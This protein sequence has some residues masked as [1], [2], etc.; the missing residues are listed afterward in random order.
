MDE[1]NKYSNFYEY[2]FV[3]L[4][5]ALNIKSGNSQHIVFDELENKLYKFY[6]IPE[7][8]TLFRNLGVQRDF[9]NP[10][11]SR[12]WLRTAIEKA[13]VSGLLIRQDIIEGSSIIVCG[14]DQADAII[15][16]Y[17][18]NVISSMNTLIE[19]LQVEKIKTIGPVYKKV[20][21]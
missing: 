11:N 17:D 6:S 2:D 1:N 3:K 10:G 18:K 15:S 13:Y 20:R 12:V 14:D 4:Y 7:F 21:K 5:C 19:M 9:K 16:F 8:N